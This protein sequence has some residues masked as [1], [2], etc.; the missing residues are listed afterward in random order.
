MEAASDPNLS[1]DLLTPDLTQ[2]CSSP[3]CWFTSPTL[4]IPKIEQILPN[5]EQVICETMPFGLQ[6]RLGG[7]G[8]FYLLYKNSAHDVLSLA[9]HS[10]PNQPKGGEAT[11]ET[12]PA[13]FG[14]TC[15]ISGQ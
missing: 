15:L 9:Y 3:A 10:I 5:R 8:R 7:N 12:K 11:S 14:N 6:S 4:L 1:D 2:A 13:H